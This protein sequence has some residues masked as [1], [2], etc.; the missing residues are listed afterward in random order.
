MKYTIYMTNKF[1]KDYKKMQKRNNFDE[2]EFIKV[3]SLLADGKELPEK[4]CNHILELEAN[5]IY[6]CHIKPDWLLVYTIN[7]DILIL[8]LTR[9]GTHS[10][11][12]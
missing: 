7:N 4:Y 6:E 2:K 8:T 1:K 9:T 10:D 11:L 5:G 3:V 12:F